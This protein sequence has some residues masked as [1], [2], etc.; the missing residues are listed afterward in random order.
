MLYGVQAVSIVALTTLETAAPWS[1]ARTLAECAVA[2]G[3]FAGM[4]VWIRLNRVALDRLE[5]CHCAP[6]SVTLRVLVSHRAERVADDPERRRAMAYSRRMASTRPL[7]PHRL[8]PAHWLPYAGAV[9][10]V[11][12]CTAVAGL[13]FGRSDLSNLIMIYL[14]GVMVVATRSASGPGPSL[15]ASALSVAAFD[16]FFIPP[17]LTLAVADAQYLVTFAVMFIVAVVI[18]SLTGRIRAQAETA[19]QRER[20]TAALYAMSRE[21]ASARGVAS[22]LDTAVR[23]IADVFR[24]QVVALVSNGDGRLTLG[25]EHPAG[26]EIA[27]AELEV[28]RSVYEHGRVAG[29]PTAPGVRALYV[30]LRASRGTLGVLGL[31]PN[32][33]AALGAPEQLHQLETFANQTA[34]ALERTQLADEAQAAQV[35]AETEQLRNA[36]LSSVSHD[37]RTPLAAI[38]GA[39]STVLEG[40]AALDPA[41]RVDLLETVYEEAERLNRLVHNLLEVT[42]LESGSLAI[43][44]EWLPLEELVGAALGRLARLLR[45]RPVATRLPDDL[46]LVPVDDVLIEQL[47]INL[48]DNAIKYTPP[49]RPIEIAAWTSDGAVTVE[50]AD[51]GPGLPAGEESRVFE[52]FYRLRARGRGGVG[53]GLAVCRGIVEAHGGRIWAEN[54]ADGGA[55]FRFTLPLQGRP[56][57]IETAGG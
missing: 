13:M 52:K 36:L 35:R 47:L 25:A 29:S 45:D 26:V 22:V 53:L 57:E 48:V 5:W 43:K 30:P 10:V 9:G 11:L 6:G 19:R 40:G 20:W 3:A 17:Y 42:R 24:S 39:A 50:V 34:L 44:K 27:G 51:S 31:R 15:L 33:P 12:I 7:R 21:L 56:P 16:F 2:F 8:R 49:G 4:L 37:L 18:S 38:T 23:H 1:T 46:P 55:A 54:R 28:A 32:E 14:L 41:T